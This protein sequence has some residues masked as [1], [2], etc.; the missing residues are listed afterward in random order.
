MAFQKPY[1]KNWCS[2]RRGRGFQLV[3]QVGAPGFGHVLDIA[4]GEPL[5][6]VEQGRVG[7]HFAEVVAEE[8]VFNEDAGDAFAD[9]Y[10]GVYCDRPYNKGSLCC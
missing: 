6:Q 2:G 10:P 9:L 8:D 1:C 3:V 5:R 7:G 4:V